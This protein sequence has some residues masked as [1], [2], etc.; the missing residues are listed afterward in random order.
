MFLVRDKAEDR[1]EK[2]NQLLVSDPAIAVLIAAA[3]FEWVV[4]RAILNLSNRPNREVRAKMDQE[5]WH[6][7]ESYKDAWKELVK[8]RYGKTL[9]QV[10]NNWSELPKAIRLR[11][12]LI[13][14][15]E[16]CSRAYA[17]AKTKII[18]AAASD[19]IAFSAANGLD[20]MKRLRV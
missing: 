5:R 17:T 4:R 3:H 8:P 7:V 13:H 12:K 16:H 1:A 11:H 14:G 6:G 10:I 9:P 19:V 15:V 18:V 20:V 2:I